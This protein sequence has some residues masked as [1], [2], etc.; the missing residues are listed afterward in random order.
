MSI[1]GAWGGITPQDLIFGNFFQEYPDY[2]ND[3]TF[4]LTEEGRLGD[5]LEELDPSIIPIRRHLE[6]GFTL[7]AE[8]AQA[9]AS[10]LVTKVQ[11]LQEIKELK[12]AR[13]QGHE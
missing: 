10:W 6:I 5:A 7:T 11:E 3:Q 4:A 2:P 8:A 1:S 12:E 9:I 13:R